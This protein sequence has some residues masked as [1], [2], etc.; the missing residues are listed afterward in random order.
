MTPGPPASCP[1]LDAERVSVWLLLEELDV[2][3]FLILEQVYVR[4]GAPVSLP[5]LCSRLR[6]LNLHRRTIARRCFLLERL[7]LVRTIA[8]S[9]LFVNPLLARAPETR[10]LLQLWHTRE[11]RGRGLSAP[12]GTSDDQR[13][14]R[15]TPSRSQ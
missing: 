7:G 14:V 5:V 2:A 10:R 15:V 1:S 11:G 9:D 3:A 8:S 13:G 12:V 6:H 4:E